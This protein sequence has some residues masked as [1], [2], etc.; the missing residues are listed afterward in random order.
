MRKNEK[1][2]ERERKRKKENEIEREISSGRYR[3]AAIYVGGMSGVYV[4][5]HAGAAAAERPVRP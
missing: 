4:G 5:G 2:K 3:R 1:E